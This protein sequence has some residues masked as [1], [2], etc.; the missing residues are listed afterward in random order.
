MTLDL[1]PG[2]VIRLGETLTL[3]VLAVEGDRVRFALEAP[4]GVTGDVGEGD[5][6]TREVS[7]WAWD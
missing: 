2:D 4:E 7:E 6:L 1:C 5:D 3:T